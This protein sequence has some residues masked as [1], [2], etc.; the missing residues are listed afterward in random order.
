MSLILIFFLLGLIYQL[1]KV[2]IRVLGITTFI[3]LIVGSASNHLIA[4]KI[5]MQKNEM[6]ES[7]RESISIKRVLICH[8]SKSF[9]IARWM[10]ENQ[11]V[12]LDEE[13]N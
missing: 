1:L 2:N 9:I 6:D 4:T 3:R 8:I 11:V 10:H 12:V 7:A 13:T 5:N